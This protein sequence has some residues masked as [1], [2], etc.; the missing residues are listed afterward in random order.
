[1]TCKAYTVPG[2]LREVYQNVH[3]DGVRL[4]L[5]TADTIPQ[6]IREYGKP[7]WNAIDRPK[8]KNSKDLFECH[9][10][11]HILHVY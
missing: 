3:K 10:V 2:L 5:W 11:H 8:A 1:V 7:Q 9:S 4:C 6:M